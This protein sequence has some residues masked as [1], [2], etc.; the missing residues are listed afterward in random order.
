MVNAEG[1][2]DA[3]ALIYRELVSPEFDFWEDKTTKKRFV[4]VYTS[5]AVDHY[6]A[7]SFIVGSRGT[8]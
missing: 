6:A 2:R 1:A 8:A 7:E 5:C 4:S 3:E